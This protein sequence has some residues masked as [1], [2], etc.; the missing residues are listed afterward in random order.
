MS[1][2]RQADPRLRLALWLGQPAET[3]L[4]VGRLE[5]QPTPTTRWTTSPSSGPNKV[6]GNG[7][8]LRR[9]A[10]PRPASSW[11]ARCSLCQRQQ[12]RLCTTMDAQRRSRP[13]RR[14]RRTPRPLASGFPVCPLTL[15][16]GGHDAGR[17]IPSPK[18]KRTTA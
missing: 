3:L 10:R 9:S 18:I 6:D 13:E 1:S 15:S 16:E 11:M 14:S 17:H 12:R 8:A 4:D 2:G 7:S 5:G